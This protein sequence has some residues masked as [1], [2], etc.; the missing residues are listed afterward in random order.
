LF[1]KKPSSDPASVSETAAEAII[2]VTVHNP[3]PY[4]QGSL[5]RNSQHA[6]LSSQT[7][8]DLYEAIPCI[9]NEIPPETCEDD[10]MVGYDIK[11][12]QPPGV[13]TGAV[14]CIEGLA[15]GDGRSEEDYAE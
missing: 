10:E 8:G 15:Y 5:A 2:T 13:S 7:L 9:S 14:I 11:G 3:L 1:V 4:K 12:K 6:V